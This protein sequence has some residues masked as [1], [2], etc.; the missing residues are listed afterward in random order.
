MDNHC[1]NLLSYLTLLGNLFINYKKE[2]EKGSVTNVVTTLGRYKV[3]GLKNL[4]QEP[5][6]WATHALKS[7]MCK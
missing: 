6:N 7:G 5:Q 3:L 1:Y 4:E 2:K